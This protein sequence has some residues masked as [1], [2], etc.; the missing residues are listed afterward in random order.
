MQNRDGK[1]PIL[2][3]Q[4]IIFQEILEQLKTVDVLGLNLPPGWGKSYLA[5]ALQ[6]HL[7]HTDILTA[8]N[9]LVDQYARD[10]PELNVVKGKTH[11]ATPE[12]YELAKS[13]ARSSKDSIF[14][15]LSALF[16]RIG[17]SRSPRCIILDEAHTLA[18][19]LRSSAT[20]SFNASRADIPRTCKD[21]YSLSKWVKNRFS[22]LQSRLKQNYSA[23]LASEFERI[24][25]IHYS[26][27]GQ[28]TEKLFKMQHRVV[29]GRKQSSFIVNETDCPAGLLRQVLR[30]DKII[31]MSGSLTKDE[32]ERLA[33]GRSWAWQTHPYLAPARQRP[34]YICSVDREYRKD[35]IVLGREVRKIYE[36]LGRP[37]TV[38][39]VT[40]GDS[41][42]LATQLKDLMP[43]TNSKQTKREAEEAFKSKGGL[44]LASGCS[45]GIDLPDDQCRCV[46]VPIIQFLNKGDLFIQKR[47]GLPGGQQWYSLKALENTI[48]RLGRGLRHAED[49]CKMYILDPLF[50]QLWMKYSNQ[51]EPLA[52]HWGYEK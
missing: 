8:S 20:T 44:W 26:I 52:I 45:E 11:Y 28:E 39:H 18:D 41:W 6:K 40:Y 9:I 10:Y 33:C 25:A 5:R 46:I 48:Q 42:G 29:R 12:E 47:L 15:P 13:L 24:A 37:P 17:S 16:T 31:L 50:P 32:T 4:E 14:N 3:H 51:F 35:F 30:A 49:H 1:K 7:G 38:V 34:V 2:P 22:Q 21:E 43:I 36:S 27:E 19:L 23:S